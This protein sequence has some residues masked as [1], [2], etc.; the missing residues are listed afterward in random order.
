MGSCSI[1]PCT[2]KAQTLRDDMAHAKRSEATLEADTGE[3]PR[4]QGSLNEGHL[5]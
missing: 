1:R 3:M 2:A 5:I 4:A